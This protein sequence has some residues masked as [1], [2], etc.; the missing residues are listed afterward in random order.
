MMFIQILLII[1]LILTFLFLG[2]SF[3]CFLLTFYSPK[4]KINPEKLDIPDGEIY[5]PYRPQMEKWILD[6][7]N[8]PCINCEIK[9]FDGLTLRG[10]YFEYE[11]GAPIELMLHGYRGTSERDLSG[12]VFRCFHLKRNV[13]IVDQRGC[14]YSDGNVITFG[15]N[16]SKDCLSWINF[17]I[18]TFGKDVKIILTGISMGASTV[19]MASG[20]DLPE[21]V[22]HILADCGFS[23]QKDIIKKVIKQIKLPANLLYPF[24]KA[25]AKIFGHF[26]LEEISPVEAIKKCKV[27]VIFFHGTSDD[28][29]PWEMSKINYEACPTH[30][31]LVLMPDL[32]H[33]LCFP[34]KMDEYYKALNEFMDEIKFRY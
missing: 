14:A 16:E 5:E 15:V 29:V 22:V 6:T 3:I 9:S 2:T 19:I 20:M 24:V 8:L 28:F 11:K 30:K 27:P 17:I 34:G 31:K 32:G 26:N 18:E 10:K 13:L 4:R 23:S 12:G 33:G 25:G 1:F 7:R 21:N